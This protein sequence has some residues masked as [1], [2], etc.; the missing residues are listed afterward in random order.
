M[1][2]PLY[3]QKQISMCHHFK[4]ELE[5]WN[6]QD[7]QIFMQTITS[8]FCGTIRFCFNY[9][10]PLPGGDNRNNNS[11]NLRIINVLERNVQKCLAFNIKTRIPLSLALVWRGKGDFILTGKR[12]LPLKKWRTSLKYEIIRDGD[13]KLPLPALSTKFNT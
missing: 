12:V 2:I 7:L 1:D 3:F 9:H 10:P 11:E 13:K 5:G 6:F 8:S 4:I